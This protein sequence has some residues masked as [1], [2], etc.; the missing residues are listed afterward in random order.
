MNT[1]NAVKLEDIVGHPV[2][3]EESWDVAD[4]LLACLTHVTNARPLFG[5]FCTE[6]G[7][8]IWTAGGAEFHGLLDGG[9]PDGGITD[10]EP[11]MAAFGIASGVSSLIVQDASQLSPGAAMTILKPLS[12]A[13]GKRFRMVLRRRDGGRQDQVQFSLFDVTAFQD[14]ARRTRTL[15]QALVKS[16]DVP[17]SDHPST[18]ALLDSVIEDLPRLFAGQ[19][20][21]EISGLSANMSGRVTTVAERMVAML[22]TFEMGDASDHWRP[23]GLNP[24]LRPIISAHNA[25]INDWHELH[26]EVL[27]T[28]DGVPALISDISEQVIHAHSFVT[29][30]SS[31]MLI[32]PT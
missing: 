16:L 30:A 4:Y 20:D 8:L 3:V 31:T 17:T 23:I 28:V 27:R 1:S 13:D 29:N 6:T 26:G 21:S 9:D 18:R 10:F 2:S 24:S 32:A 14:V 25:P 7:R 12:G 22:R 5:V 15:A 11:L 19:G